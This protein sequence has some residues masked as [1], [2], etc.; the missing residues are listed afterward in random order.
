MPASA[1]CKVCLAP[2][3]PDASGHCAYCGAILTDADLELESVFDD[4]DHAPADLTTTVASLPKGPHD[5]AL[6]HL[7]PPHPH[8]PAGHSQLTRDLEEKAR[9]AAEGAF[10]FAPIQH[11]PNPGASPDPLFEDP[12]TPLEESSEAEEFLRSVENPRPQGR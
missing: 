7:A 6:S 10:D 9:S 12:E 11:S 2:L 4:N 1:H 3:T 8:S 5:A